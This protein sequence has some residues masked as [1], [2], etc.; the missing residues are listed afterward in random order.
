MTQ[1][2]FQRMRTDDEFLAPTAE[3][4]LPNPGEQVVW[5]D[6]DAGLS[7]AVYRVIERLGPSEGESLDDAMF[8]LAGENGSFFEALACELAA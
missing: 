2:L 6:P 5:N 7:T 8:V 1:R 4:P 3:R